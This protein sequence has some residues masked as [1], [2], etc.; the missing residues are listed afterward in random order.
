MVVLRLICI[1]ILVDFLTCAQ[2]LEDIEGGTPAHPLRKNVLPLA[3]H[4]SRVDILW[5]RKMQH[6]SSFDSL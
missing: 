3:S 2:R 4:L 5:R 1:G 6:D